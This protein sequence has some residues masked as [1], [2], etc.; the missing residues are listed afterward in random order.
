MVL[1]GTV[2]TT[3]GRSVRLRSGDLEVCSA[4]KAVDIASTR[5]MGHLYNVHKL[6]LGA[7]GTSLVYPISKNLSIINHIFQTFA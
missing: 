7:S 3:S 5:M 6:T 2:A 1:L 4:H